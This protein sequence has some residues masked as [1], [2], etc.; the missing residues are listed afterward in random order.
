M[1]SPRRLID[2]RD[3]A[4]LEDWRSVSD[5]VMG[6]VSEATMRWRDAGYASFLGNVSLKNN[7]GFASVHVPLEKGMLAGADALE[8][9][10]RGDG[11]RYSLRLRKDDAFDG[12]SYRLDFTPLPDQWQLIRLPLSEFRPV[13]RGRELTSAPALQAE[14]V[15]RLGIL[16][17]RQAGEFS[18]DIQWMDCLPAGLVDQHKTK[19]EGEIA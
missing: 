10:C 15:V 14:E 16:I 7:G 1:L 3:P 8:L 19:S 4:I 6:G 13:F 12:I 5:P 9:N 11:R 18:L 17:A 2:F